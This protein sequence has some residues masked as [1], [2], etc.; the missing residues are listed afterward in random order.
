MSGAALD[1]ATQRL[2]R[3][4]DDGDIAG[5]VAAVARDG[6]IVYFQSL[7]IMDIEQV[8]PM[9]EDALFR[10]YSMTRQV[11]SAAVL[12][13]YEEGKFQLDDP[14]EMYLPE[15]ENQQVLVDSG[16]TDISQTKARLGDITVTH[17]LT[18]T[19]GLGSRSSRLYRENRVR[20]KNI[21]LDQMV[22]N[23]A[24]I[25]LFHDPGTQFRYGIHATVLGK[26]V[27]VWSG[28]SFEDYLKEE[29]LAPLAMDSTM[30]WASG[31]DLERLAV[32]YRPTDGRLLPYQIETIPFTMR[33]RLIEGGVG[34]LSTVMDYMNFSQ[35]ILD[36]GMHNGNRVLQQ[37]TVDLMFQNAVPA[38][39]MPIGNSGYWVGSGWT[40][41]GFNLVMDSSAY[42]FPVSEGTIWWDGSA[43]TRYF[44]DPVQ[45][46]VI[47]IMAQV[48]PSSGGGFR[49]NF[50]RLV[51]AAISARY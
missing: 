37:A 12:K 15:F 17:L 8:K 3:H 21:T 23:A 38:Q 42:N 14:I 18:H 2:Q 46:T 40:F 5:V 9:R 51:D 34:L 6:K 26:L 20:D 28:Q 27:E 10:T 11:T 4:I 44:I 24:R 33:P 16:S 43:G 13:L 29:L 45:N 41:G 48:S 39:A 47:V 1:V 7:G 35:M 31:D 49:E 32:V 22:E 50:S 25:P 19:S 30:F 36:G